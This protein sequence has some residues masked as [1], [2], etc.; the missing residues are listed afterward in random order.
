MSKA[1][2]LYLD[3]IGKEHPLEQAEEQRLAEAIHQGDA[4]ALDKLVHANLKYVITVAKQYK[5]RG[6]PF[7]DLVSEGNVGLLKAASKFDGSK[8]VRFVTFASAYVRQAIEKALG[9]SDARIMSVDAPI[10]EG[11]KN[12]ITLLKVL[13]DPNST[14]ADTLANLPMELNHVRTL[15]KVLNE[16]QQ[17]VMEKLLGLN[18]ERMNMRE[19]ADSMG[20]K[21]ER[22]RQIRDVA[23]RKMSKANRASGELLL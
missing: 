3:H 22:V 12:T 19:V 15:L 14:H 13:E 21:R 20:L 10:P 2:D 7:E 5:D 18:G 23:L 16:R 9:V 11:S 17:K 8:G 6:L 4:K 1:L